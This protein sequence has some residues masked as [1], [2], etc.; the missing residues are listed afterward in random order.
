MGKESKEQLLRARQSLEKS[1]IQV[2]D[3]TGKL[4]EPLKALED[5]QR[6]AVVML[7]LLLQGMALAKRPPVRMRADIPARFKEELDA[8]CPP[9]GTVAVSKDLCFEATVSYVSALA[10]CENE[11]KDEDGC[12]EAWG[13]G[14]QSVMC[15]MEAIEEMKAEIG[16][17]LGKQ[18]TPGPIP[19]PIEHSQE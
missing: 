2:V 16:A 6:D 14:A 10:T 1:L 3:A 4:L 13:P 19:W 5:G 7:G 11:G 18:K 8:I 15:V 9:L 17:L 12:P